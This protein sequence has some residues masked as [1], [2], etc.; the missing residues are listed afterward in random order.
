MRAFVLQL[1]RLGAGCWRGRAR[2][3]VDYNECHGELDP[4]FKASVCVCVCVVWSRFDGGN[5]FGSF[6]RRTSRVP[7]GRGAGLIFSWFSR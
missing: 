2:G 5:P 4:S 6:V 1:H 3:V 7:S